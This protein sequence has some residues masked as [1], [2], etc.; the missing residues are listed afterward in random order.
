ML[1]H[2]HYAGLFPLAALGE[3]EISISDLQI[4]IGETVWQIRHF[5]VRVRIL[6]YALPTLVHGVRQ[7]GVAKTD[8]SIGPICFDEKPAAERARHFATVD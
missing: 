4:E 8:I 6:Y 2:L 5:F 3:I 1:V 7:N